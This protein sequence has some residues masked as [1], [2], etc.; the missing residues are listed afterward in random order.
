MSFSVDRLLFSFFKSG[1]KLK[2]PSKEIIK[3][4]TNLLL[5]VLVL[6]YFT[7]GLSKLRYGGFNWLDGSTLSFY[8]QD[9]TGDYPEGKKQLLIGRS[10]TDKDFEWKGKYNLY[11][12][13]YGNY[14]SNPKIRAI[15]TWLGSNKIVMSGLSVLTIILELGGFIV[16]IN[17]RLRNLYLI[18]AIGMHSSI[19]FVMGL[20]FLNYKVICLCLMDWQSAWETVTGMFKKSVHKIRSLNNA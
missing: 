14:R 6:T 16:F 9:H 3:L 7:A 20:G 5:L 15:N 17:P 1:A 13:T 18:S 12:H 10:A 8:I 4:G 19:G 2:E 11:S